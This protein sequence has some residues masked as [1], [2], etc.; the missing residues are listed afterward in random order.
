[1]N[2]LQNETSPYL[3]QHADN[4]VDW[5]PWGA[6]A[7]EKARR[8]DKPVLLSIGYS[9]CHWCHVMAHESFEDEATA[10]VMN[11][12]FVNIKVDR[13]E[14]PDIDKIYQTAHQLITRRGGGWP[15]TVFLTP[16]GQLPFFA[17]TYFP[18]E[19]RY[20]MPAF[21][22]LLMQVAQYFETHRDEV[23]QQATAVVHALGSFEAGSADPAYM[24]DASPLAGLRAQ[25]EGNFD[26]DWGGF[27]DAPKFPH[28]SSLEYLL[29]HW[30]ASAHGEEP[31][32]QALFMTALT[33]TRMIEGGI[34]D[35]L[36][37]G[38]FRYSVDREWS[39]PHFEKMLYDNGPL[40]ALL[41]QLWQASGDDTFRRAAH[42]T[43]D[44]ALR[45]MRGPDG[46]F[47]STLDADSEGE[48]GKFYAWRPDEVATALTESEYAAFGCRFGLNLPPNFEG[49]WHL[50]VRDSIENAAAAAGQINS[51]AN[52][53][54]NSSREKLLNIRN[55]RIWPG[56]DEKILTSWNAL[57]IRGM[58][59]AGR[60]LGRDDLIDAAVSGVQFLRTNLVDQNGGRKQLLAVRADGQARFSA[61]LDDHAFLIDTLLEVLQARW[62]TALLE[63]ATQLADRLLSDFADEVRGGFYFTASNHEKLV[64]RSRTFSDDSMPSGNGVAAL[65]LGRLGHLLGEHRYLTA[66]ERTLQAGGT[67]MADFPHG[68]ASLIIALDEYLDPPEIIVIRGTR[69]DAT[70]W[71]RTISALYAPR[72]LVF[73]IPAEETALPGALAERTATDS[74]VAYRCK[75]MQCDL[76]LTSR[77]ELIMA[78]K[79]A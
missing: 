31:D 18:N 22:E 69:T 27:G 44:W 8:E 70:E 12:L 10:A 65:A 43:A 59:I 28:V 42:E 30:R 60:A 47:W 73:A 72:R 15:L 58:A 21:A 26:A 61:Y 25:L 2:R 62:D 39:I 14:R 24:P 41:A 71:S 11:R 45:E 1:M 75:G 6:E 5:Y 33:L 55:Q 19:P 32:V 64:H 16:D 38:F 54:I 52:A 4:P 74:T 48:E 46:G 29:R 35:Q 53:L 56:R 36:G 13:E 23:V 77:E 57:M 78:V 68:H 63:F 50:Q 7:L 66:A 67:L 51:G 79:E 3:L 40:L 34:Y 76:P 9:A 49:Q 20:G 37:G 17:G